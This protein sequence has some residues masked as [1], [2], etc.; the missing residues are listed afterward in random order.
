MFNTDLLLHHL[1]VFIILLFSITITILRPRYWFPCL[2]V[3]V[4]AAYLAQ[5]VTLSAVF[6]IIGLVLLGLG[7]QKAK[8]WAKPFLQ[9]LLIAGC[10]SLA[11][12]LIPGF[13][14]LLIIDKSEKSPLSMPFSLYLNWDKAMIL[15]LL[16]SAWPTLITKS[17]QSSTLKLVRPYQQFLL[18]LL[19]FM[20]I[21]LV[22]IYL[23]LIAFDVN[24]PI[25]WWLFALNNLL[26]TC[27]VEEVFFRGFIL[28]KLHQ[29]LALVPALFISAI[30][31]GLAHFAGGLSYVFV[32]TLAGVL[33]GIVYLWTGHIRYSIAVHFLLNM[34][35]LTFFTY[36]MLR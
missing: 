28:Q 22:S 18:G 33:Y 19:L 21:F 13:N 34:T 36:P 12:H 31:F 4:L 27:V 26:I 10:I 17:S 1:G 9:V 35:H 29:R 25:W 3:A 32:A 5:T 30:L 23:E 24:L 15:F 2:I 14:N 16:L 7:S 20:F 11:L 6:S 8:K